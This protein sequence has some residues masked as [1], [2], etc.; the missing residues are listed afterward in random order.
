MNGK[1]IL[2]RAETIAL[3]KYQVNLKDYP[4][5]SL[6]HQLDIHGKLLMGL[7]QLVQD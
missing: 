5:Q 7:W 4:I 2:E 6:F 1:A 3:S